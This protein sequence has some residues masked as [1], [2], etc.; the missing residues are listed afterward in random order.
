[1]CTLRSRYD[2]NN[3]SLDTTKTY[4]SFCVYIFLDKKKYLNLLRLS[5]FYRTPLLYTYNRQT[6]FI[7][8]RYCVQFLTLKS[9]ILTDIFRNASRFLQRLCTSSTLWLGYS[10]GLIPD[11]TEFIF[12]NLAQCNLPPIFLHNKSRRSFPTSYRRKT[13]NIYLHYVYVVRSK[14]SRPDIQKPRQMEN[15]V[16]DI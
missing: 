7:F 3:I 8:T 15:A 11:G 9:P 16:R 14:S 10:M 1:M 13:L 12:Q 2:D 4:D 6:C 5:Y